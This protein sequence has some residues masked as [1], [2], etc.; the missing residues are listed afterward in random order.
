MSATNTK[1]QHYKD[2]DD[3]EGTVVINEMYLTFVLALLRGHLNV[4][5][6]RDGCRLYQD[7]FTGDF[8]M[9][10]RF[11]ISSCGDEGLARSDFAGY[12]E[13]ELPERLEQMQKER[14]ERSDTT[15]H[16]E[17]DSTLV[18]HNVRLEFLL[19][20]MRGTLT[21]LEERDDSKLYRDRRTGCFFADDH[22][23]VVR[24][25]SDFERDAREEFEENTA[26]AGTAVRSEPPHDMPSSNRRR[27]RK[28]PTKAA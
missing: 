11:V 26:S 2:L 20:S 15:F 24:Y 3:L 23:G 28:V 21:L 13:E 7:R 1:L 10:G 14:R 19:A 25:P 17:V 8:Y 18:E 4:I 6:E 27:N 5:E 22:L 9:D 16:E 12:V